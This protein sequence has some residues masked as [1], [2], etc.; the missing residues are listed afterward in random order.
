[1]QSIKETTSI[2]FWLIIDAILF[3]IL[4]FAFG[5]SIV[6]GA[7]L[8]S[9]L[10]FGL[11]AICAALYRRRKPARSNLE[12]LFEQLKAEELKKRS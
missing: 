4:I 7:I 8:S 3:Y 9:V 1:M 11:F 10:S 6:T 2:I 5:F 12:E